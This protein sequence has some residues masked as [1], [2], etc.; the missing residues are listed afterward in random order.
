M[1]D[2][3]RL[4]QNIPI[5]SYVQRYVQLKKKGANYWGLC[6]FHSE[7]SPSFSVSP[8]KGIF[9]CFGCGK[10]GNLITFVQL[11][12]RLDF[13]ETLKLLSE[14]SGIALEGGA[15]KSTE[16]D[17]R[18]Y[19]FSIN[20]KARDLFASRIGEPA[21]AQY[22]QKRNIR[23]DS[24]KTF[25]LGFAPGEYRF[26]EKNLGK[27][28]LQSEAGKLEKA[29]LE[30][31]LLGRGGDNSVYNRFQ[32]RLMFP[33]IDVRGKCIGFGGRIIENKENTGKYV[34]SPD[35][36]VFHKKNSL[37]NIN[38]AKEAI[39]KDQQ[40]VVVEGYL[41]VIGLYQAGIDNVVAPL[42]TAFTEPQAR[43]LKRY[44]D[45]VIFFFDSDSAGVEASLKALSVARGAKLDARVV[46]QN[47]EKD[48]F[49]LS[50]S[51]SQVDLL[52]L[53]D[54]ARSEMAFVLWYYFN[55][56]YKISHI[57]EKRTAIENFFEYTGSLSQEWEKDEYIK[58]AAKVLNIEEQ[59]LKSDYKKYIKTGH[60]RQEYAEKQTSREKTPRLEKE[61]LSVLLR[62]P[63]F[64]EKEELLNEMQW[65]H[66]NIYLLFS[67]FRDRLKAGEFWK[68][69][70][71]NHAM[72]V[73]PEDLGNLLAEI[74]IEME[75]VFEKWQKIQSD[76]SP[77]G[78]EKFFLGK[79]ESL[80]FL[81][82]KDRV[83]EEIKEMQARLIS[84][85][86]MQNEDSDSLMHELQDLINQKSKID[87]FLTSRKI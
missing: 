82:K 41:D 84:A 8:E 86:H 11:Y 23:E 17:Q 66:K 75:E 52:A 64:W 49:D 18:D 80:V 16:K 44:T 56:K 26:L 25:S 55:Y 67:F 71:L 87:D 31:G 39:R 2:A 74:M 33:I 20:Q 42:G 63:S 28:L 4:L 68:W 47:S 85:E 7:K 57:T 61:I 6:P 36:I 45:R 22:L 32:Q 83:N 10:G 40:A 15:K 54:T 14:Y 65:T 53:L 59:S 27:N 13:P 79:L 51:L 78:F 37:Y 35:S 34:N 5:E 62:F 12:E 50:Q 30:L 60:I 73:L 1:S 3:E 43:L 70:E 58:S 81:H 19:L 77:E 69:T 9:K 72:T 29:L 76:D 48:P 21:V 46:S 38:R 24:A